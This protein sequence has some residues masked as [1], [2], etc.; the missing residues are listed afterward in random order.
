MPRV[1]HAAKVDRGP[2]A[3]Y[4]LAATDIEDEPPDVDDLE[5]CAET[6]WRDRSGN[7]ALSPQQT[8]SR[9]RTSRGSLPTCSYVEYLLEKYADLREEFEEPSAITMRVSGRRCKL[10][11][12]WNKPCTVCCACD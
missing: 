9:T 7:Q 4:D 8:I 2:E 6:P 3:E 10:D 1:S 12:S 5:P 11:P